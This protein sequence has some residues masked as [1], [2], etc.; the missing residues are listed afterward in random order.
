MRN[1]INYATFKTCVTGEIAG[2]VTATQM[3]DIPVG[4]GAVALQAAKS[5]VGNVYVGGAGVTK[6]D[7]STDTTTGIELEPGE[8]LQFMPV[9]NL[10]VWYY[11]CDN[12]GDD[13]IYM[14][15]N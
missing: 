9:T 15:L 8:V 5:N 11:I 10:N 2:S 1:L 6:P 7:G 13:I 12:A 14:I 3:P 4:D